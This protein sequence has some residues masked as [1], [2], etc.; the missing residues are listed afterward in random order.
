MS[1][2]SMSSLAISALLLAAAAATPSA[3]AGDSACKPAF[4]AMEKAAM[5]PNHQVATETEGKGQAPTRSELI[6]DGRKMY[7]MTA[8]KWTT[9]PYDAA[10]TVKDMREAEGQARCKYV[11]DDSVGGEAVTVYSEHRDADIQVW[12]SKSRGLP[13][14]QTIDIDG[15]HNDVRFDY[16]NV[17]A[18]AGVP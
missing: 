12:I 6:F 8:G 5:T 11:G 18:P 4:A 1:I 17:R 3:H 15:S 10:Q 9:V 2:R 13:L 16:S 14:R 7:V